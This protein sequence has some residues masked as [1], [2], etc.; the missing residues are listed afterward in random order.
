MKKTFKI[1]FMKRKAIVLLLIV[2]PMLM[3][4]NCKRENTIPQVF[5]HSWKLVGFGSI[6]DIQIKNAEPK[7]CET[8][9]VLT[10]KNDGT[11]SGHSSTNQLLGA[12]QLNENNKIQIL[13]L[14]GTEINELLDGKLFVRSLKDIF[15]YEINNSELKLYYSD[16][17]YLLFKRK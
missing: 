3:G 14:E 9:Y 17:E 15:K 10:F 12:Y 16:I 13:R 6:N 1:L 4:A 7:N 2:L 11:L 8:C 5:L